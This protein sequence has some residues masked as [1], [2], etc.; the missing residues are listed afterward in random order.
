[1]FDKNK[2]GIINK[3]SIRNGAGLI[4]V[5]FLQGSRPSPIQEHLACFLPGL[6]ALDIYHNHNNKNKERDLEYAKSLAY[7]CYQTYM[8]Q[9]TH[10]APERVLFNN[11]GFESKLKFNILRPETV[12]SLYLLNQV[13][14]DPIFKKWGWDI[15]LAFEKESKVSNGYS[16]IRDVNIPGSN[17]DNTESFWP[18]ETLKYLYL[19]FD[20]EKKIDLDQYVF[21]TEA[22]PFSIN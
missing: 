3:L 7:T 2:E 19:L 9:K 21:N 17:Q 1:M 15:Y 12:E 18:A 8:R 14:G 13:T 6:I 22:H 10:L 16:S 11:E 4:H 5:G 20:T